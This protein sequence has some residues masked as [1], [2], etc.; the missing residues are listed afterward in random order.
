[1]IIFYLRAHGIIGALGGWSSEDVAYGLIDYCVVIE[2]VGFAIA[3]S[4][5]FTYK[6]Y[7]PCNYVSTPLQPSSSAEEG[8]GGGSVGVGTYSDPLSGGGL[9]DNSGTEGDVTDQSSNSGT[10]RTTSYKPPALLSQP[11]NFK[12][13]LW[14]SAHPRETIEDIQRLRAGLIDS[15]ITRNGSN[16]NINNN[17]NNGNDDSPLRPGSISLQ[18]I[19]S[20]DEQD[21]EEEPPPEQ[22][23]V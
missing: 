7:L 10:R 12:D 16:S 20:N 14:S 15:A 13:A 1:M 2:M 9:P 22:T 21:N 11:M 3:H 19:D 6:E 23:L 18:Q 5:T 4:Y 17:T 8:G